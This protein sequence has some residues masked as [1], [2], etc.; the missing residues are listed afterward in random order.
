MGRALARRVVASGRRRSALRSLSLHGRLPGSVWKRLPVEPGTEFVVPVAGRGFRYASAPGDLSARA[1]FWRGLGGLEAETLP[2]FVDLA[3]RSS[4]FADVGAHTGLYSLTAL[5]ANPDIRVTA[6]EPV[7]RVAAVLR[8]NIDLNGWSDR[9]TIVEAA[10][11][12]DDGTAE[13]SIPGMQL[14]SSARLTAAH[15]RDLPGRTVTVPSH[16]LDSIAPDADLVKIDVEGAEHLVLAGMAAMQARPTIVIECLPEGPIDETES[17]VE[18]HGYRRIHLR[19]DG[20]H[21][22]ERIVP[23]PARVDRNFL[24]LPRS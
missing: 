8:R 7:D 14:P 6:F 17:Y 23:D 19:H 10:I 16:R 2:I 13:L 22:V 18:A 12:D 15:Y 21:Q 1:L 11:G 24:L 5:A 9:C 4:H 20:Q 3:R